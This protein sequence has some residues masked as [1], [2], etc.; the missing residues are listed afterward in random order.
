MAR[1]GSAGLVV[2]QPPLTL[3]PQAR[4]SPYPRVPPQPPPDPGQDDTYYRATFEDP[5]SAKYPHQKAI[6]DLEQFIE[7]L[8]R[9]RDRQVAVIRDVFV[10]YKPKAPRHRVAPD[11]YV[12][13]DHTDEVIKAEGTFKTWREGRTPDF[14]MEV[15][16]PG[17]EERD[18]TH[19][20]DLYGQLGVSEYFMFQP[21]EARPGPDRGNPGRRLQGFRLQGDSYR[22]IQPG[23]D[24]SIHSLT[25]DASL[26]PERG[27]VRLRDTETGLVVPT[28]SEAD[29]ALK[30]EARARRASDERA[31]ESDERARESDER[32]RESEERAR[33]SEERANREARARRASDERA[34]REARARRESDERAAREAAGRLM[35]RQRIKELQ[36][37]VRLLQRSRGGGRGR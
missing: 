32:A 25:L 12:V 16:S 17:T 5:L 24:G 34:N 26:F 6:G 14:V 20:K 4:P 22:E 21:D 18:R 7:A 10:H 36:E 37:Q 27:S 30:A 28:A 33:E 8:F 3:G 9:N 31:R 11:L 2:D 13:L 29:Q 35:D 23:A 15:L 19:K 1:N